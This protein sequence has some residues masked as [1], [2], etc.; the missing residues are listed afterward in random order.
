MVSCYRNLFNNGRF[1]W[2]FA[3]Q[4]PSCMQDIPLHVTLLS[5]GNAL[6]THENAK[7]KKFG[8]GCSYYISSKIGSSLCGAM[9]RCNKRNPQPSYIADHFN[10]LDQV[11]QKNFHQ[12]FHDF[13]DLIIFI[14]LFI[15]RRTVLLWFV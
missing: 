7:K 13:L 15:I 3:G 10:S 1:A 5:F 14:Y 9:S 4:I 12:L 8:Q 11:F 2:K 6:T